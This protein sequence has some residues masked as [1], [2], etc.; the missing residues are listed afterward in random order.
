MKILIISLPRTGS[1]SL[2]KKISIENNL[3]PIGE[4][5]NNTNN[6]IEIYKNFDWNTE[7]NFVVKT[8]I[9]HMSLDFYIDFVK[10]FD[11]IILLSRLNLK[12]CAE[13]LAYAAHYKDYAS[14]YKWHKTPNLEKNIQLVN[15][16]SEKLIELSKLINVEISYYENIFDINST[17]KLR[18]NDIKTKNII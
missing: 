6:N 10:L 4:P 8:H 18:K 16:F 11:K 9:N 7:N 3:K 1:T 14:E 15:S 13:S 17:E 12:E 5:F 2:L